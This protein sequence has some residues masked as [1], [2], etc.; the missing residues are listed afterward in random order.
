MMG[1][2]RQGE[3]KRDLAQRVEEWAASFGY[4]PSGTSSSSS[5]MQQ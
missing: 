5:T 2:G 4:R 3:A 1:T